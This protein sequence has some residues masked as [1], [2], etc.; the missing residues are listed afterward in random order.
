MPTQILKLHKLKCLCI[1]PSLPVG[2][3]SGLLAQT[4]HLKPES[5]IYLDTRQDHPQNFTTLGGL[6]ASITHKIHHQVQVRGT[7]PNI[8]SWQALSINFKHIGAPTKVWTFVQSL[9]HMSLKFKI[10][11]SWNIL[12]IKYN[13]S[14]YSKTLLIPCLAIHSIWWYLPPIRHILPILLWISIYLAP[15]SPLTVIHLQKE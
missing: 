12:K 15:L 4:C 6:C 3:L 1:I 5:R 13:Y 2:K 14:L 10:H 9:T 11:K 7:H 8:C